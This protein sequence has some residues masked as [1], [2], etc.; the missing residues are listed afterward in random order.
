MGALNSRSQPPKASWKKVRLLHGKKQG[1][2]VSTDMRAASQ[3]YA[4]GLRGYVQAGLATWSRT[5]VW[6][7]PQL[8]SAG[9][10]RDSVL[11]PGMKEEPCIE[12]KLT[13]GLAVCALDGWKRQRLQLQKQRQPC[14]PTFPP[15]P[16]LAHPNIE[17]MLRGH[18][19]A[20]LAYLCSR[21]SKFGLIWPSAEWMI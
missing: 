14:E 21:D 4:W 17:I 9:S 3:T 8:M 15:T 20:P 12:L 2:R 6:P 18:R 16:T 1:N 13:S 10:G 7:E 5:Q 19:R 11:L